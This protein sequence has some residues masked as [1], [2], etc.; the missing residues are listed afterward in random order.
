MV[1][2][3]LCRLL[4]QLSTSRDC[5]VKIFIPCCLIPFKQILSF[6]SIWKFVF[7]RFAMPIS[8]A[9]CYQKTTNFVFKCDYHWFSAIW[10]TYWNKKW[11]HK[12][13]SKLRVSNVISYKEFSR[14]SSLH[15]ILIKF[16]LIF[17]FIQAQ[18]HY[19]FVQK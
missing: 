13:G 18:A 10:C 16:L 19:N 9:N 5:N 15:F 7:Y 6:L 4:K 12:N 1:K 3:L 14:D 2:L 8:I 11:R 17:N